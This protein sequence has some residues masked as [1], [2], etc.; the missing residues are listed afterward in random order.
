MLPNLP[1]THLRVSSSNHPLAR[2]GVSRKGSYHAKLETINKL[3]PRKSSSVYHQS[4]HCSVISPS[5]TKR[6]SIEQMVIQNS[7]V[8]PWYPNMVRRIYRCAL[9]SI[10]YR[11][12][13]QHNIS[14]KCTAGFDMSD[15][16]VSVRFLSCTRCRI[17]RRQLGPYCNT[18]PALRATTTTVIRY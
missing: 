3:L 17:K 11:M 12:P 14:A 8:G 9:F 5:L 1:D 4:V 2:W 15:S 18:I 13:S 16:Q 7:L 6:L 10:P